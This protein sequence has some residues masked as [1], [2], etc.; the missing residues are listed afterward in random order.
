MNPRPSRAAEA[1][2]AQ[3]ATTSHS[4]RLWRGGATP[5]GG[6]HRPP[7]DGRGFV[8]SLSRLERLAARVLVAQE[9]EDLLGPTAADDVLELGAEVG[10]QAD[11]LDHDVD[12][13][14]GVAHLADPVVDQDVLG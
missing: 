14:P 4:R 7:G 9:L 3:G 11:A 13:P 6:M 5:R 10:D 8:H 12:D 2:A 1:P